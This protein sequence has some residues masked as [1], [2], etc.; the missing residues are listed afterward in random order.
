MISAV[1]ASSAKND[2]VVMEMKA[3]ARVDM[4]ASSD[5]AKAA[6]G[7]GSTFTAKAY[8]YKNGGHEN[9]QAIV[10]VEDEGN[11]RAGF[12]RTKRKQ[13]NL[14]LSHLIALTL[15]NRTVNFRAILGSPDVRQ[16]LLVLASRFQQSYTD[17]KQS[18]IDASGLGRFSECQTSLTTR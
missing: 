17:L 4:P 14:S 10:T 5:S 8:P 12:A 9:Y 16:K 18:R 7:F 2:S 6:V 13:N 1:V 15:W 3:V 11:A